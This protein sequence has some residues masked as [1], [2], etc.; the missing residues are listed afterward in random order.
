[1]CPVLHEL[2]AADFL[3]A[4]QVLAN[5]IGFDAL[6]ARDQGISLAVWVDETS[7]GAHIE[8]PYNEECLVQPTETS[9][10][11]AGCIRLV[12]FA[13]VRTS[14]WPDRQIPTDGG[15]LYPPRDSDV[16]TLNSLRPIAG[17]WPSSKGGEQLSSKNSGRPSS[18]NSG[19]PSSET[20]GAA[21]E[22]SGG[23]NTEITV[24]V[25]VEHLIAYHD[26]GASSNGPLALTPCSASAGCAR[27][28]VDSAIDDDN[29]EGP[30]WCARAR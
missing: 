14:T 1:L 5:S 8:Q 6:F 2:I 13:D 11:Q 15:K 26:S 21:L 30:S 29:D 4:S 17:N 23:C 7:R 9:R 22:K 25:L 20:T 16:C 18:E 12:E 27:A 19:R 10:R 24:A 28:G 3:Q